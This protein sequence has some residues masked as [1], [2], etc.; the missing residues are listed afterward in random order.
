MFST[1]SKYVILSKA[2][3]GGSIEEPARMIPPWQTEANSIRQEQDIVISVAGQ[4]LPREAPCELR[5]RFK[6]SL[7]F[8]GSQVTSVGYEM[9]R[10]SSTSNHQHPTDS[11]KTLFGLRIA[12][13]Q[14]THQKLKSS[15]LNEL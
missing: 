8:V 9:T 15:F 1:H 5:R 13:L 2:Q 4:F 11:P 6:L 7:T 3:R 12:G 14:L 10:R